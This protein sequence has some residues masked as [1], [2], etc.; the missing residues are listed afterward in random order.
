MSS[1]CL[2]VIGEVVLFSESFRRDLVSLGTF[3]AM[4]T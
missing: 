3:S 1:L 4:S 2:Y